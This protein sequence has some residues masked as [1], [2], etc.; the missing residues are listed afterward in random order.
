MNTGCDFRNFKLFQ[1]FE[2]ILSL[3]VLLL[4][5][6]TARKM[7]L[8]K[9]IGEILRNEQIKILSLPFMKQTFSLY[10][11]LKIAIIFTLKRSLKA[12]YR[13]IP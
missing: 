13:T 3:T 1:H 11:A 5:T 4:L 7:D 6:T 8:V 12:T 10:W 2:K 9:E